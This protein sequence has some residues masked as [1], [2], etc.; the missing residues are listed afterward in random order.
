MNTSV[1]LTCRKQSRSSSS[2]ED[3]ED[4]SDSS[5]GSTSGSGDSDSDETSSS[6]DRVLARLTH[7]QV[8]NT[9]TMPKYNTNT[10]SPETSCVAIYCVLIF[11]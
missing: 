9:Y 1:K 5:S 11:I 6:S 7:N 8:L 10:I 3:D 2:S 4:A